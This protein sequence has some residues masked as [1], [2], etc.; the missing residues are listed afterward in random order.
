MVN[1]FQEMLEMANFAALAR[2]TPQTMCMTIQQ[3]STT[4][5]IVATQDLVH[6][7]DFGWTSQQLVGTLIG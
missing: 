4:T 7:G 1:I 2:Y 3:L 5:L 6:R